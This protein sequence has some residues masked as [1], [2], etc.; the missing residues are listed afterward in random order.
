MHAAPADAHPRFPLAA[1]L[2]VAGLVGVLF[3]L[4]PLSSGSRV[5]PSIGAGCVV[6]VAC[7]LYRRA[8]LRR[9]DAAPTLAAAKSPWHR[10]RLRVGV[11][12]LFAACLAP[13]AIDLYPWYTESVWRNGHGLFVPLLAFAVGRAA[14]RDA[15]EPASSSAWG[16][17]PLALGLALIVLDAGPRTLTLAVLGATL[18]ASGVSLL[19]L[20][21]ALT[22]RLA[23]AIGLL[24]FLA[25]LPPALASPLA[26][27]TASAIGT[28]HL[29]QALG[30]PVLR[31]GVGLILPQNMFNISVRCS[32]F[33][34]AY[35]AT[36]VAIALGATSGSWTRTALMLA[37]IWPLT[38]LSNVL[39]ST[40]LVA[41]CESR[42]IGFLQT[43]LHGISGI[44]AY[45]FVVGCL[46]LIAGSRARR[47]LLT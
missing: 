21:A 42:G 6:A 11:V 16:F 43:P 2:W 19:L 38:W 24:L 30:F 5:L 28:E 3:A 34:I 40:A 41:F 18:A 7:F 22:R 25:P 35:G 10:D 20:G 14:L 23:V 27:P 31:E 26:L 32:G 39:R 37:S 15:P 13:A 47:R 29:L 8:C 9:A 12:V 4:S 45:L 17:A 46:A 36:A 33:S 44:A 1:E